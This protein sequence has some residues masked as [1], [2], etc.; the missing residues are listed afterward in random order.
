MMNTNSSV[1]R[2]ISDDQLN[3][4]EE[5]LVV[6]EHLAKISLAMSPSAKRRLQARKLEIEFRNDADDF[7]PPRH[8]L[9]YLVR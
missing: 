9:L 2:E 4:I 5:C 6:A 8:L 7:I 1:D 3:N